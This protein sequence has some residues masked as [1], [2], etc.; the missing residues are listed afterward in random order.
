MLSNNDRETDNERNHVTR[1]LP[2]AAFA[3]IPKTAG[4]TLIYLLRRNFGSRH[5]D[6]QRRRR[7]HPLDLY[8]PCDLN[9]DLRLCPRLASIAGHHLQPHVDMG[10]FSDHLDW[11]TFLRNPIKRYISHYL[12]SVE[13]M[14]SKL[15]IDQWLDIDP[16]YRTNTQVVHLAGR[17]D[18]DAA[19]QILSERFQAVGLLE[20]FDESLLIFRH[21]LGLKGFEVCY[22][23]PKNVGKTSD[24]RERVM[25]RFDEYKD[26]IYE[27][28]ELDLQ[29]Y[30]WVLNDLWPQQVA[31]YGKERL[32]RDAETEFIGYRPS[33]ADKRNLATSLLQRNILY[34]PAVRI[35]RWLQHRKRS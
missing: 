2:I 32:K 1:V 27:N 21:R 24:L 31:Q 35:H 4:Q 23:R 22:D 16:L 34:K 13:V 7:S 33:I 29:L 25:D 5:L 3:H 14:G 12:F 8:R 17:Q 18:L 30:E 20:H 11:Y 15:T 10:E 26:R 9:I 28:N 19:Q 6:V